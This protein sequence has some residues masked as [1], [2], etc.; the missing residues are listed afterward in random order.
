MTTTA[1]GRIPRLICAS[2]ISSALLISAGATTAIAATQSPMP[3]QQIPRDDSGGSSDTGD[4]NGNGTDTGNQPSDTGGQN[5]NG[6]TSNGDHPN[7]SSDNG[8]GNTGDQSGSGSDTGNQPSDNGAATTHNGRQENPSTN[9]HG[10]DQ[11]NPQQEGAGIDQTN[12]QHNKSSSTVHPPDVVAPPEGNG[13]VGIGG[14]HQDTNVKGPKSPPATGTA[15]QYNEAQADLKMVLDFA[16]SNC[17]NAGSLVALPATPFDCMVDTASQ[18]TNGWYPKDAADC[19]IQKYVRFITE[20]PVN[21][22]AK[23]SIDCS[24]YSGST[25]I[26]DECFVGS[27]K[28]R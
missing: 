20:A 18:F 3:V 2:C 25:N 19:V 21:P 4:Q 16:N 22:G 23:K 5:G 7:T 28:Q 14:S 8:G 26:P 15:P 6:T 11:T 9:D 13:Y 10:I 12:P 27:S 17:L 1:R 24:K